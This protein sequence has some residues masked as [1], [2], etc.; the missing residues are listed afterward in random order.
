MQFKKKDNTDKEENL[1]R[2]MQLRVHGRY[3][4]KALK[5]RTPLACF[6]SWVGYKRGGVGG[7]SYP[8]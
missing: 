3:D 2:E 8:K 6:A 7:L 4:A 5:I 1:I